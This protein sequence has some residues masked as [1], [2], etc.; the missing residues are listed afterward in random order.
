MRVILLQDVK[1]LGKAGALI[2]VSEGHGRNF[3]FPRKL[4]KEATPGALKEWEATQEAIRRREARLLAEAKAA[5]ERLKDLTV[6]LKAK[7]GEGGKL[8]GSVT[9]KEIA[10]A[11]K[12]QL[13]VDADKRKIELP[14]H[15]NALGTYGFTLKLH[16]QVHVDMKVSITPEA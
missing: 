14:E 7:A 2:E 1:D 11:I 16:T 4:A 10:A 15:I 5:G 3:L 13:K 9:S 12:A 6:S 8:Y